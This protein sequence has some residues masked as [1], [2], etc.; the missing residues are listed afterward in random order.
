MDT[1]RVDVCWGT[2]GREL[3]RERWTTGICAEAARVR[4]HGFGSDGGAQ[5]GW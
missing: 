3:D 1:G 2:D 5:R 4:H